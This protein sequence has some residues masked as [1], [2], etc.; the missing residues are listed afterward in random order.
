MFVKSVE[1]LIID[2]LY[3]KLPNRWKYLHIGGRMDERMA[4][5]GREGACKGGLHTFGVAA[6]K[7]VS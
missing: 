5:N 6:Q 3:S 4:R 1:I 2:I 7:S